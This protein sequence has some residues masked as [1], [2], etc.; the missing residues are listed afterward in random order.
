MAYQTFIRIQGQDIVGLASGQFQQLGPVV[1]KILP[2]HLV[3]F[4]RHL[5]GKGSGHFYSAVC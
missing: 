5:I 4:T 3:Y 2:L 1:A